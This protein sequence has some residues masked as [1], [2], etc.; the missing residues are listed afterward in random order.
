MVGESKGAKGHAF[1][2]SASADR[3]LM[4]SLGAII[5]VYT[6]RYRFQTGTAPTGLG[7]NFYPQA[8]AD[9]RKLDRG[10]ASQDAPR[11]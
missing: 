5:A 4:E 6:S 7:V 8:P 11:P 10:R 2:A 3:F 9:W 1:C